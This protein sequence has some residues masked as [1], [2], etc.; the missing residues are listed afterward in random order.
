MNYAEIRYLWTWRL[1]SPPEKLWPLVTNTDRFNRDC[2]F[3]DVIMVRP[4]EIQGPQMPD[5]RRLRAKHFG[6]TIEWDERPFEWVSPLRFGVERI[7][8]KG[9]F[10][11]IR[12]HCEMTLTEDG[13]TEL[14]YQTWF[15]P[16]NFFGR[17][18]LFFG[19]SRFQFQRPFDRVF[20]RYDHLIQSGKV[21]SDIIKNPRLARGA[22][23]RLKLI[24]ARLHD[25]DQ[26]SELID[27]LIDF[28]VQADDISV[29]RIKPYLL[30]DLWKQDRRT[31]LQLCLHATRAGL[32]DFSWD[33]LCPLCRGAKSIVPTLSDVKTQIHCDACQIDFTTNLEQSVELTFH[34]NPALR[35]V[36]RIEYCVGG[37]QITP[38]IVAQNKLAAGASTTI[39]LRLPTGRYR[40]RTMP[41]SGSQFIRVSETGPTAFTVDLAESIPDDLPLTTDGKATLH[42]NTDQGRH[43]MIEHLGWTDQAAT[44]REVTVLQTF[45]DLFS[46]EVLRPGEQISVGSVTLVFTDIKNSTQ[47]YRAIGDAPA[48]GRVL[49]HFAV[50]RACV[51]ESGGAIIK[52]MGDAIMAVFPQP[53]PALQAMRKAQQQLRTPADG[54][55]IDL[56]VGVHHGPC[57]AINQ[58]ERL[59]YFGSTVN[60]A[61]RLGDISSG[62]DIVLSD[63][64]RHDP[65][66]AAY[67]ESINTGHNLVRETV[68]VRGFNDESFDI[69][70]LQPDP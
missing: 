45:R 33:I 53:I 19:G 13:G 4:E 30:A 25:L 5:A 70:H 15:T 29:L 31:L 67:L 63:Q 17:V 9:P 50:L 18:A 14:V 20:K 64:V 59:D 65:E 56:K 44:A 46:K 34:P 10:A 40:I 43:V 16:A 2:G 49:N 24:K 39:P 36:K 8:Q 68:A 1:Q 37:P 11:S 28:V 26:P 52:T 7:F 55:P 41:A 48:F 35:P 27:R 58:N 62:R 61:A 66:V 12:A 38:H 60:L 69:W 23:A 3:P 57:L 21:E 32:L 42:N 51:Q 6:L 54:N 47:L 22:H